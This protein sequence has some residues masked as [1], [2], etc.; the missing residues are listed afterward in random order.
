VRDF[1]TSEGQLPKESNH[2]T[3]EGVKP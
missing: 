1:A 2:K 3:T